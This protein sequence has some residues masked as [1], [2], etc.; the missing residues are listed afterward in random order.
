MN[1]FF[2]Y[3]KQ[4]VAHTFD[5]NTYYFF[6]NEIK[7]CCYSFSAAAGIDSLAIWPLCPST[8]WWDNPR[9]FQRSVL[10]FKIIL[11]AKIRARYIVMHRS[12]H[13][14]WCF[15]R[16]TLECGMCDLPASSQSL[17]RKMLIIIANN[18]KN[19]DLS[20]LNRC[21]TGMVLSI[22]HHQPVFFFIWKHMTER[23]KCTK[24]NLN[25]STNMKITTKLADKFFSFKKILFFWQSDK[26]RPSL[27]FFSNVWSAFNN[28]T[29]AAIIVVV[30]FIWKKK[31]S[32]IQFFFLSTNPLSPAFLLHIRA[33]ETTKN[34]TYKKHNI[35]L[36]VCL[37][38]GL[39]SLICCIVCVR[40]WILFGYCCCCR[41][42]FFFFCLFP[43]HS[44]QQFLL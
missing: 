15:H 28:V 36:K 25:Q 26:K 38:L 32:T 16:K 17:K 6:L 43:L 37:P 13:D 5:V 31:E 8:S 11:I 7:P 10:N 1:G 12:M 4:I 40:L 27:F 35:R 23:N 21:L 18:L 30:L 22:F 44:R 19:V 39:T 3:F 41:L 24:R 33:S 34:K 2:F 9:I 29:T 42:L 20:T 14:K